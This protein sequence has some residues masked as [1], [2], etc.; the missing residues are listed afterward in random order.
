MERRMFILLFVLGSVIHASEL[1]ESIQ[2]ESMLDQSL[3]ATVRTGQMTFREIDPVTLTAITVKYFFP[4]SKEDKENTVWQ[5]VFER[6]KNLI[7]VGKFCVVYQS[8]ENARARRDLCLKNEGEIILEELL[9][10]QTSTREY[11]E[12]QN[13]FLMNQVLRPAKTHKHS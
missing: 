3:G 13:S 2:E 6:S 5:M 10:E 4:N 11:T 7:D 12:Q 1:E 9:K 8:L